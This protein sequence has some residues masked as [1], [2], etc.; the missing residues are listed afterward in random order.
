MEIYIDNLRADTDASTAVSVSL[1]IAAITDP[2]KGRAGYTRSIRIPMTPHNDHVFGYAAEIHACDRFNATP[3][4]G[5]IEHEGAV[6]IEGPLYLS[7]CERAPKTPAATYPATGGNTASGTTGNTASNTAGGTTG[8]TASGT[9]GGTTRG[10][11]A[12]GGFYL[13]HIIGASKEWAQRA[14]VRSLRSTAIDFTKLLNGANIAAGWTDDSPV[15]FLPVRREPTALDYS[16]GN[17]IPAMKVLSCDDYHPFIHAA[18][19][20]RAIFAGSGYTVDSDFADGPLFRSLY[21]S[22]N[23]PTADTSVVKANMDFLARRFAPASATAN[24]LGQVFADPHR[25]GFTIGNLVDTA[26]PEQPDANGE[27]R[28]DVFSNN[29]CFRMDGDRIA[30]VPTAPVS[31][32]FQY[33]LK[34][35]TDCRIASRTELSGFNRIYLGEAAPRRFRLVNTYPDLREN[36]TSGRS[37]K[38]AVFDHVA[39][40]QYQLRYTATLPTGSTMTISGS[41]VSARFNPIN[42]TTT[43]PVGDPKLYYRTS[44][45]AAWTLYPE[46]W[47]LYDGFVTENSTA[48]VELTLRTAPETVTPSSPKYFDTIFFEG[49][50]PGA[51]LTIGDRVWVRPVFYAQPTEGSTVTFTDVAVHD[52]TQMDFIDS[53]RQMFNLRFHTDNRSRTVRI[54]PRGEFRPRVGAGNPNGSGM[55][56]GAGD[57]DF[58]NGT[59]GTDSTGGRIVDWTDRIDLGRPVTVEELGGELSETMVWQYR[60]GD[61]AVTR[62]NRSTGG[63]MGRWSAP[64]EHSAAADTVSVWENPMFTCSLNAVGGYLGAPSASLVQVGDP[65]A[66]ILDRTENL[67]FPAKIVRYE[68]M[69][70]LP[71]GEVWG[72]PSERAEYPALAFHSPASGTDSGAGAETPAA[73]GIGSAATAMGAEISESGFTLCFE[74]RD[75]CTGLHSRYDRDV[76]TWNNSRRVTLWIALSPPEVESLSFPN[77]SGPDFHTTYRLDLDGE[78]GLYSLEEVCDYDPAAT[79]TKCVFIKQIP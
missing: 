45:G 25:T 4:T 56:N 9:A 59:N 55:A 2:Q 72:W 40:R 63:T 74:D 33:H 64:V 26:D 65:S 48:D 77:G 5:R 62:H 76:R 30:F 50:A 27:T 32:G 39:G 18:T 17:V 57:T 79:T 42:I 41:I 71:A 36:F 31:V 43:M 3:H 44:T 53:L 8:N 49:A 58:M 24:S 69:R 54:E 20:L 13:V 38:L 29:G 23:Y 10:A 67:N 68:G 60:S 12:T 46:D 70:S 78:T 1:S 75:G 47:A 21:I 7:R 73:T 66:D 34:Y 22:G 52:A 11:A 14:A 35:T 16:S 51:T 6:L 37:Y 15:K 28:N 61:G 19:L